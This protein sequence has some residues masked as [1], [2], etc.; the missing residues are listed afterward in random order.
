MEYRESWLRVAALSESRFAFLAMSLQHR[1][2]GELKVFPSS[3]LQFPEFV[4]FDNLDVGI[5]LEKI[6][7]FTLYVFLE[8][9][10]SLKAK[11]LVS[12]NDAGILGT[13]KSFLTLP[14]LSTISL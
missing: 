9:I 11:F 4:P 8:I 1:L 3:Q 6:Q 12:F 2:L 14:A 7:G 5:S 13:T 10:E